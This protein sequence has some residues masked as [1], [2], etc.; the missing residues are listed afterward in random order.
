MTDAEILRNV[1]LGTLLDNVSNNLIGRRVL[2]AMK[3]ARMDER[4][5]AGSDI[6]IACMN[7]DLL[8]ICEKAGDFIVRSN[9]T[10]LTGAPHNE[11]NEGDEH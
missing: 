4:V 1:G 3:Q 7:G 5:Q 10:K 11:R 2:K 8:D 9:A 6:Q